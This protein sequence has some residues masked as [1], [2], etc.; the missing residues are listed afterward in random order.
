M[1]AHRAVY[2]AAHDELKSLRKHASITG[3]NLR[4]LVEVPPAV[5]R[6]IEQ[7]CVEHPHECEDIREG[8]AMRDWMLERL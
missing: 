2:W 5:R 1:S 3:C 8:L 4:E 6:R 7:Y